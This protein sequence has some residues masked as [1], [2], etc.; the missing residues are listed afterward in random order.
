MATLISTASSCHVLQ[1]P[2]NEKDDK[3]NL[4]VRTG[5]AATLYNSFIFTFGGL[6]I[7]LEL[8]EFSISEIFNKFGNLN[9]TR[10]L[11]QFLSGELFYLNIIEK[12]WI[13]FV[14]ESTELRPQPRL[15]HQICAINNCIYLF[16][17]LIEE[18]N[19]LVPINDLW[20]FNLSTNKWTLLHD[21]SNFE[22]DD[23]IPCP[24]YSHKMTLISS[25]SFVNKKDHFGIFIAGGKDHGSNLIYDNLV[26]DLVDK[27]YVGSEPIKLKVQKEMTEEYNVKTD[28]EGCINIDQCSSMVVNFIDELEITKKKKNESTTTSINNTK[29]ESL[30]V[31]G[32]SQSKEINNNT[33]LNFK[34][35]KAIKKGKI[36]HVH[37]KNKE[38][39]TIPYNLRF[40]TGG[41]F[42][43][44]IVITG[45]LPNEYDISLF[46]YNKPTGKW[47]KLNIFCNHNYGSHRFWGGFVWQSHHKV[48]LIGNYQTSKTT[49]SI[50]FF[51]SMVT[52]SLPITNL[53]ASSELSGGHYHAADGSRIYF[54][55]E[56][57]SSSSSSE[58]EL[59]KQALSEDGLVYDIRKQS[60]TSV[61]TDKSPTAISF[62]D[63]VHYAAPKTSYT[64][65]RSVFPPTAVTLGRNAFDRYGDMISDFEIISCNGDRI[66]VGLIVLMER[67]GGYFI[68]LL[69]KGYISA[70]EKFENKEREK[71]KK[72]KEKKELE[73]EKVREEDVPNLVK[74]TFRLPFQNEQPQN[75]SPSSNLPEDKDK[76]MSI[77]S[78]I[79]PHQQIDMLLQNLPPQSPIPQ[80]PI[81]PTPSTST[82]SFKSS[83]R[84]NSQDLMNSPRS[85]LINTLTQLRNIPTTQQS[86]FASPRASISGSLT[87]TV[88]Q[89]RKYSS[90]NEGERPSLST[91]NSSNEGINERPSLST[92]NSTEESLDIE[93]TLPIINSDF[94]MESSLIPRKLYFPFSTVTVKAFCEYL[95][96]GQIGNKW[97]LTPTLLDNMIIARMYK[98]PLLYDLISE[99]LFGI[100]GRK[101]AFVLGKSNGLKKRYF[102]LLKKTNS[103]KDPNFKFPMD[104]YESFMDSIDDGKLDYQLLI[105]SSHMNKKK[106]EIKEDFDS[107]DEVEM[108]YMDQEE[109]KNSNSTIESL[110]SPNS[111]P[112]SN[113]ILRCI[114]EAAIFT[115]DMKLITR[116]ENLKDISFEEIENKIEELELKYEKIQKGETNLESEVVSES[117]QEENTKSMFGT[118][119]E[120]NHFSPP[121]A[122]SFHR[123]SESAISP[124]PSVLH[125]HHLT[126]HPS[127]SASSLTTSAT[128]SKEKIPTRKKIHSLIS[129]TIS[130]KTE[131]LASSSSSIKSI[132]KKHSF[133]HR[134]KK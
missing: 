96:T 22:N 106:E 91:I 103:P 49:S 125:P 82:T 72:E 25:L 33:L 59:E 132:G 11:N 84:K 23:S 74:P 5:S 30:I 31:Y 60:I 4:N 3:L 13:R 94:Q 79:D 85:S 35:G 50:R 48:I 100:I 80:D 24:R 131:E 108:T 46:I 87:P 42:G 75:L 78:A 34:I 54:K 18:N 77:S 15:L 29:E 64:T 63:Y 111:P 119:N 113:Q 61:S 8:N 105:K 26:F 57:S 101:E 36:L 69:S 107:D 71:L 99:V 37:R 128:T 134:N 86:P 92:I 47:S 41:I 27:R 115:S 9:S 130:N 2:S 127:H 118:F 73:K 110:I 39:L 70:I 122:P 98:I 32:P 76:N 45:F 6:T 12:S 112:P 1:L 7:G 114:N 116:S 124:A 56:R 52:I 51:T 66:P 121:P 129:K 53:L 40:P 38:I 67:W 83:S 117:E 55:D 68:Y 93:S 95:Y 120:L 44:N 65:I 97:L 28:E 17:G 126:L 109:I 62:T 133:F 21:G 14:H 10:P 123:E 20:E 16:G 90:S 102:D 104:E 43:Q 81:P 89:F 88:S 58:E 19:D